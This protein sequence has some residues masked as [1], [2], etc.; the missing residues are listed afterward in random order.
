MSNSAEAEAHG[1]HTVGN[2]NVEYRSADGGPTGESPI[3]S[4]IWG[5]IVS[6]GNPDK[7][8]NGM[9]LAR[10]SALLRGSGKR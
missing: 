6:R 3:G 7:M 4:R 8:R 10:G 2:E 5:G 9:D 1:L